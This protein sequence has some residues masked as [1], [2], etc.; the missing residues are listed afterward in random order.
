MTTND[1]PPQ[2][3]LQQLIQGFQVRRVG[4]VKRRHEKGGQHDTCELVFNSNLRGAN[5]HV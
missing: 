2:L 5:N 3:V 1:F 4:V